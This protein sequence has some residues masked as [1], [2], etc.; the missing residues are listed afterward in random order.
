MK[1][2]FTNGQKRLQQNLLIQLWRFIVLSIKFMRLTQKDFS[3]PNESEKPS[4][5]VQN[6]SLIQA[7]S[8]KFVYKDNAPVASDQKLSE[9]KKSET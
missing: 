1:Y 4:N 5:S 2:V 9:S 3:R 6:P 8:S 7:H